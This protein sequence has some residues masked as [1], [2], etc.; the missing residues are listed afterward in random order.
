MKVL[1]YRYGNICEPDI[2]EQFERSGL[3]VD[4]IETEIEDKDF[5]AANRVDAVS[6]KLDADRYLFVFSLNFFPDISKVCSIYG[7]RYLTWV[8]DS[9]VPELFSQEIQNSCNRVFL[10]DK[11][12]YEDLHA[13]NETGIFH[14]P[15]GTNVERWDKVIAG[16]T[17]DDRRKY[18]G[19]ISFVG[20][21]YLD[22]DAYLSIHASEYLRGYVDSL[23][24][25]QKQLQG[26]NL[27][28][29]SLKSDV[30][31]E[32]K[33]KL[34]GSFVKSEHTVM[35]MDAYCAAHRILDIHLSSLERIELLK[36]LSREFDVNLFTRS[37]TTAFKDCP[38]LKT[39]GGVMTL[40]E[41]PK[42]FH[43][44][45]INLNITI[46]SIEKGASLRIWDVMGCGGFLISNYQEELTEYLTA[47][48]DYDYY[49]DPD[50]L[51]DKCAFYLKHDSIRERIAQNG[52]EKT[53]KYHTYANRMPE[54][55]KVLL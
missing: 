18:S 44:S 17:P 2:M 3:S 49:S 21:L 45:K 10:F 30:I 32:L 25:A 53:R 11:K 36:A 40:T 19:D 27:I 5:T 52:Y 26:Y 1:F 33:S 51:I 31:T 12:Q 37:D 43:L 24:L 13:Y 4:T 20:S 38:G 29:K 6:K 7:I 48:E 16:I 50:E 46:R 8:V 23:Y 28:E 55:I 41:M 42:V 14:L 34:P 22:K 9:P 47:G 39:K 54:L 35:D 15:L